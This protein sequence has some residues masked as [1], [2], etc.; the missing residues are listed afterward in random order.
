MEGN[1]VSYQIHLT[2]CSQRLCMPRAKKDASTAATTRVRKK[3]KKLSKSIGFPGRLLKRP[4]R[5]GCPETRSPIYSKVY[6]YTSVQ[7]IHYLSSI[8]LSL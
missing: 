3:E 2:I 1:E 4:V 7:L 8:L 6:S 5:A